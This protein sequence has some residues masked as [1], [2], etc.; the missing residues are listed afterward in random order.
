MILYEITKNVV[1]GREMTLSYALIWSIYA[2]RNAIDDVPVH[3]GA[4]KGR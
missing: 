3:D 1:L 2:A 4:C